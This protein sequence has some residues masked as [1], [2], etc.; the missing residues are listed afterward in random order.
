MGHVGLGC[1]GTSVICASLQMRTK[2]SEAA[3]ETPFAKAAGAKYNRGIIAFTE[4]MS[5]CQ[6][7]PDIGLRIIQTH[8]FILSTCT[9]YGCHKYNL[10]TMD[11]LVNQIG[12]F[13]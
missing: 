13:A 7:M 6:H 5:T 9:R 11:I 3:T 2:A 8:L 1:L 10:F 12:S 4:S